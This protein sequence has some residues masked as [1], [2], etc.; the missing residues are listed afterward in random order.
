M[1]RWSNNIIPTTLIDEEDMNLD[2]ESVLAMFSDV[3]VSGPSEFGIEE[4]KAT[5]SEVA[6]VPEAGMR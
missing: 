6:E 2:I 4:S 3:N 5:H 1:E